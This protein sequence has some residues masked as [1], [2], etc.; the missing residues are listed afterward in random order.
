MVKRVNKWTIPTNKSIANEKDT[1]T[2][3]IITPQIYTESTKFNDISAA[4]KKQ[5][6]YD[7]Y[8]CSLKFHIFTHFLAWFYL[9]ADI[10][11][12][13]KNVMKKRLKYQQTKLCEH[14]VFSSKFYLLWCVYSP[15]MWPCPLHCDMGHFALSKKKKKWEQTYF[16]FKTQPNEWQISKTF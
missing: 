7:A 3:V 13:C 10:P 9:D 15:V 16:K 2:G 5:R 14:S 8:K 12:G 1:T 11:K 6:L 4:E